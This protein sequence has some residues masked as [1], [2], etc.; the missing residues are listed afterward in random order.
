MLVIKSVGAHVFLECL[1]ENT[2]RAI[3]LPPALTSTKCSLFGALSI[4]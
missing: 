2:E 1:Y 3:A 4:I